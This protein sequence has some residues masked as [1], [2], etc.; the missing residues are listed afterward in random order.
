M[1]PSFVEAVP[2]SRKGAK[3]LCR[4]G[5]SRS[6]SMASTRYPRAAVIHAAWASAMER[7]V[8]PL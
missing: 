5:A 3:Y 6:Q 8:P 1:S 4:P 7:P 2:S